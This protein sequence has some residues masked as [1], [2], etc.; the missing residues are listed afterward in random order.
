MV[1]VM[2]ILGMARVVVKDG[3]VIEVGEPQ[4]KWCPL[5]EKARGIKEIS[6]E[7][8]RKNMEFRIRDF[9]LFTP[10]RKLEMDVFVGFGASEVMMTGLNRGL[11]DA[12]VT[13]CDGA[14]TV[15]TANPRLV[16]G[17][18]ARISG[19]VETEPIPEVIAGIEQR[20]GTVLDPQHASIDP[21]KGVERA[22]QMGYRKIAVSV[23]DALTASRI[24]DLENAQGLDVFIIAAHTTG[25]T[26]ENAVELLK[27]TDIVTA[28]ASRNLRTLIKPVA[29]VGTAV[30]LF[31][32]TQKG[33]ELLLERA[34]E[35]DSPIL[36]NTMP[37]PVLPGQKQP[38]ELI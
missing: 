3:K 11:L 8:V 9:G 28:C 38:R 12:T 36:I 34:K 5:F 23:I 4:I 27:Y 1:H 17:M 26:K 14:G 7:E 37:L 25:L 13:V 18:G 31:A 24:R 2:E 30:P 6:S 35:V 33:K 16:Q 21:A 15:I 22:A 29:Q 32:V 10:Q 20:Q 19:L